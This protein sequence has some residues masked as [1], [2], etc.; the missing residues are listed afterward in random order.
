M[1][2]LALPLQFNADYIALVTL[3]GGLSAATA[4]VIVE[5]VA[6]STMVSNDL[7][8]PFFIRSGRGGS[9]L[10]SGDIG[11]KIL[12]VRRMAILAPR[13]LTFISFTPSRRRSPQL[14]WWLLPASRRLR[15][16]SL[17]G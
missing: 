12:I 15:R 17:G 14:G 8:V 7:V 6:L 9:T 10:G 4:M 2:V 3:I 1:T 11:A 16:F 13:W 5:C